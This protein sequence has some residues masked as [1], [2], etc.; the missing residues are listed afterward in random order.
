MGRMAGAELGGLDAPPLSARESTRAAWIL[1]AMR[2]GYAYNWFD[3]GPALPRIGATF[4]VGPSDWGLLIAVFL[5]GAGAFQV[6]AGFLARRY[7]ARSLSIG[8]SALLA[9]AAIGSAFAP[10][11]PLLLLARGLAGVGAASFFSPA[12]GLVAELFPPGRRGLPVG[13]FS[14]AF[15]GG[16]AVGILATALLIPEIG[17]RP[18]ILLGGAL[19]GLL[20]AA[21][22]LGIP[23]AAG[24]R[25]ARPTPSRPRVPAALRFR[26]VWVVGFAFIGLEGATFA[27][28]QFI[29]PYGEQVRLWSAALAGVVGMMFVLPSVV[30]GP[31][32][33]QLA[34]RRRDHRTQFLLASGVGAAALACIPIAGAAGAI[35]IGTTFSFSYGY[36][37]A[38][39]YVLPQFWPAVPREEIPLAIGLFN[40]MQLAGGALV[41]YL[42]GWVVATRSYPI[43]WESLA[44]VQLATLVAL[45]ALP[46][47]AARP[48]VGPPPAEATALP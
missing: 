3:V 44:A 15:S 16:A 14:S 28:G 13:G 41:A 10:T 1:I 4:G 36:V 29:V 12:I 19:L 43:A 8:G 6:P 48:P 30:G 33:G 2:A 35:A 47:A 37:Y 45:V 25:P 20:T 40:A 9:I 5:V 26:G 24:G 7:G 31:V 21:G 42:F 23:A 32:G 18:S 39:M 38:V 22:A 17:W 27:T 11:F 34:E 46:T